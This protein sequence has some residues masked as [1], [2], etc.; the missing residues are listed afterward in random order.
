[1]PV[2]LTA[3]L[4]LG[5]LAAAPPPSVVLITLDTTR[6]DYVGRAEGSA[7]LTPNLDALATKGVRFRNALT[8][9]PLT[10]P[11]HCSLLTG[12]EPPAHGVRDNGVASLPAGIPTLAE[13]FA[14]RGY[15]TAAV[16]ASRV[17]DRRFGLARGFEVYDDFIVAE[18]P[19]EQ[20]YPERD[21]AQITTAALA[22]SRSAKLEARRPYFL[23]VHYYDPHAPY[24]PPGDW[25]GASAARRY[26]GEIAF[27]DREIGRLLSG[28]PDGG[29]RIV[30]AV[31]DHGEMLG[32]H[33]EKEH[34]VFLYQSALAVPLILSGPGV[35][36]G[37]VVDEPAATRGLAATLVALAVEGTDVR[38]F[39][40]ELPG[41]RSPAPGMAAPVYSETDMPASAYGWSPLAAA[42]D[43]RLRL[44]VAPR[45]ELYDLRADPGESRNLWGKPEEAESVRR[46]Q[47]VIA[48]ANRV[49]RAAGP[50]ADS[51][52]LAESLRSLGYLSGSSGRAGSID[53]KDGIRLLDEFEKAKDLTRSGRSRDAVSALTR[54]VK[55]SPGN[56]PFMAR[57]A[58]AQA[59]A[60]E[61]GDAIQTVGDALT[62]NPGLDFLH[63]Q[64]ARLL[65]QA[66][67]IEDARAAFRAALAIN[68]RLAPAWLGL[69]ELAARRGGPGEERRV[70]NEAV[71]ADV[72]S[73]AIYARLAQV[74]LAAGE[75]PAAA[76]HALEAI[77][78]LPEFAQAWWIAGEVA[79]KQGRPELALERYEKAL[80]LGLEDPRALVR[81]GRRLIDSGRRAEAEVYLRKA[82]VV[83]AGT[84]SSEDARRLLAEKP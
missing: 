78:L 35:P 6:A 65:L 46:L 37:R 7:P 58:E 72:Q 31:G 1:M 21:A 24:L 62:L 55:E 82:I 41:V 19:G 68:P 8:A 3:L 69:S 47:R 84:A 56:V 52:E 76:T 34:G 33:G 77:R 30:A 80:A 63:L 20:G 32:E 83:G 44:I 17:L 81:V 4:L 71:A 67:R 28:L 74:E 10:L 26:A 9:S 40:S 66:R 11:A 53:P 42:T 45:P 22:W 39:G 50:P 73:A 51:A 23:W 43:E 57:L 29:R 60:G 27:V 5:W 36:R 79:E 75:T 70:L 64:L 14:A 54:L 25:K 49:S 48:E 12:L 59:A 16:V 18:K 15:R 2:A 61:I 38:P 13:A